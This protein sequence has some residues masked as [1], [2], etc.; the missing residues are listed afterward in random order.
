MALNGS[1]YGNILGSVV[2]AYNPQ[3]GSA[4]NSLFSRPSAAAPVPV[5]QAVA[6]PPPKS[7]AL[8]YA[9]IGGGVLFGI[10]AIFLIVR[11]TR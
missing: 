10:G 4:I 3:A 8:M 6:A 1:D 9:L 5:S 7:P 2:G 11:L